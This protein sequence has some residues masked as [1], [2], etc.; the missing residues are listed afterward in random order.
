MF[1][2]KLIT[3]SVGAA[4]SLSVAMPVVADTIGFDFDQD[5]VFTPVDGL[6]WLPGNAL[7]VD[8]IPLAD[9]S[10]FT[11]FIQSELTSVSGTGGVTNIPTGA[12]GPFEITY[13]ISLNEI[14]ADSNDIDG[15]GIADTVDFNHSGGTVNIWYDDFSAGTTNADGIT[16]NS[17][18][19]YD[20]GTLILSASVNPT[21]LGAGFSLTGGS[22]NNNIQSLDGFGNNDLPGIRTVQGS[23]DA[24]VEAAIGFFNPTF[25]QGINNDTIIEF[26]LNAT[27]EDPFD[28]INP[29]LSVAG[30]T[31]VYGPDSIN[32]LGQ[33][34]EDFHFEADANSS[35]NTQAVPEPASIALLGIGLSLISVSHIRRRR[36]LA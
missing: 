34:P 23:G 31:P 21:I 11:T 19:G 17:G 8:A 6:D 22:A 20:D 30:N 7:A 24:T 18:L 36:K 10:T 14:V 28:N 13:E 12:A 15:D 32:G 35:F 26:L 27:L 3:S 5:G 2:K 25:F 9:D 33:G 1:K 16:G 29:E 4:L